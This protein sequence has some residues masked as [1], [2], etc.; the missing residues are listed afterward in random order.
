MIKTRTPGIY[1][2]EIS[3]L[4][5]SVAPVATAVPGFVGYTKTQGE[6]DGET[7]DPQTPVRITSLLEFTS[8]F[9]GPYSE[10]FDVTIS[11]PPTGETTP[12][13]EVAAGSSG[14][15]PYLLHYQLQ[16]YFANGGGP[17]HVV[18]VGTYNETLTGSAGK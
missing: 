16:M 17:C 15:S 1:I 6:R 11:D 9:G 8:I 18:S 4:P 3:T 7:L 12:G 5:V 2:Q 13:I 10:T 14:L